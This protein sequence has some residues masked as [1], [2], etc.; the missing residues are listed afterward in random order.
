MPLPACLAAASWGAGVC[1]CVSSPTRLRTTECPDRLE[2]GG[3]LSFAAMASA[4]D[5]FHA[6]GGF[7][8]AFRIRLR[9]D[10]ELLF[11]PDSVNLISCDGATVRECTE[12]SEEPGGRNG[13]G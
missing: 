11:L 5:D 9:P 10:E 1:A 4:A 3:G 8:P 2:S 12:D 7:T 6:P 13:C